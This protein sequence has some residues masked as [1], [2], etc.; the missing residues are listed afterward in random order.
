MLVFHVM[1]GLDLRQCM[2]A[3]RFEPFGSQSFFNRLRIFDFDDKDSMLMAFDDKSVSVFNIDLFGGKKPAQFI[4]TTG[5][6]R[7]QN[8]DDFLQLKRDTIYFKCL[9]SFFQIIYNQ[10]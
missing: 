2:G 3:D 1:K 6:V 8:G 7:D 9:A 5:F 4:Q 10:T